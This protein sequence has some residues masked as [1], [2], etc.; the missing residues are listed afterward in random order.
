LGLVSTCNAG[1]AG[2]WRDEYNKHF[3]GRRVVVLPDNDGP[4][5]KHAEAVAA[6]LAGVAESVRVLVLPGLEDKGDVSD[7]LAG[8]GLAGGG[9]AAEL[10][11]LAADCPEWAPAPQVEP[12]AEPVEITNAEIEREED[13][14]HI[15]PLPMSE[16]IGRIVERANDW[17]RRVGGS[18]FVDDQGICWLNSQADLF[19]WLARLAGNVPWRRATGCVSKE[20]TFAELRRTA[21]EHR[22]IETLPHEPRIDGHYY[23]CTFPAAGDG[24]HLAELLAYF[25]LATAADVQLLA[26]ALAT[27]L[28]GGPVGTR[29]AFMFT[30]RTGRGKGKSKLAGFLAELWGGGVDVSPNEDASKIKTRLLT[31]EA[32]PLR[33]ALLDNVKTTR[34]SWGELE[35]L[36]TSG[37]IS[38]HR[39]Y[40]GEASRPNYLT[41]LITL[42][43]ASLSTD[44]AQR[45]VEIQLA[46]PDYAGGWEESVRTFIAAS[47]DKIIGDLVGL[48]RREPKPLSRRTRWATWEAAVLS[49][50]ATPNECLDLIVQRRG[51]VDV[52]KEEGEIVEDYFRAKLD[53]FGYNLERDDVFVPNDIA[54]G[55]YRDATGDRHVKTTGMSRAVKQMFGENR[56]Q[57]LVPARV[58]RRGARGLRWIGEHA[59]GSDV[60]KTDL[61]A[62]L[63]QKREDGG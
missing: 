57:H 53:S 37:A 22:A 18:L 16:V 48:L 2:K 63:V 44:M 51:A 19:G 35:A 46:E 6:S 5:R 36:I 24:S 28:W 1:G 49:R 17:P 29:P 15:V 54:L 23:S 33:V 50:V 25:K 41:W 10:A 52:E 27:P 21:R 7:W 43:G 62:R 55:W 42:N 30:A 9:T 12:D 56:L 32:L 26:A 39:M 3:S 61:P 11:Q 47:R 38:G 40:A 31:P 8:G 20:E 45:V 58:G 14:E 13:G 59:M 34:F 4:G 60:T